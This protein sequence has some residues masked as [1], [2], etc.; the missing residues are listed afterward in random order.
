MNAPSKTLLIAAA[1]LTFGAGVAR[2]GIIIP[3]L[4]ASVVG[5]GGTAGATATRQLNGTAGQAA[6]GLSGGA[7]NLLCHGF[8]CFGGVRVVSVDPPGNPGPRAPLTFAFG[9]A[10]PTPSRGAVAMQLALP[11]AAEIQFAIFDADGR[12]VGG[13]GSQHFEPGSY[14]LR[15]DGHDD[16]GAAVTPGLYFG[17]LL[18][19]GAERGTRRIVFIR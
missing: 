5:N 12:L 17:R 10:A 8:W 2:A 7:V 18:V 3:Q 4:R 1:A 13:R 11:K 14:V 9:P 15:W 19:D 6:V 16:R